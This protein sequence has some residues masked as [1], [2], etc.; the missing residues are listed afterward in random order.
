M[1]IVFYRCIHPAEP[2]GTEPVSSRVTATD[3][4]R[5]I[6]LGELKFP[7]KKIWTKFV[8]SLQRGQ[9]G[10]RDLDVTVENVKWVRPTE[11]QDQQDIPCK[12]E[13]IVEEGKP[14]PP[15]KTSYPLPSH[16]QGD[17]NE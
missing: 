10:M 17:K 16:M 6:E 12:D 2:D 4:G 9:V 13:N 14:L 5:T 3:E 15:T 11:S 8:G 7:S 1:L